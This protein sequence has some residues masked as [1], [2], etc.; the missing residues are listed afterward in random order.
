[1]ENTKRRKPFP[2]YIVVFLAPAVII[3]TIF[4]I[5]PLLNSLRLSFYT[6]MTPTRKSSTVFRTTL[7]Y[8]QIVNTPHVFGGP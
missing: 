4:M 3:Y 6:L 1:M 8:S 2:F 7:N 5:Y